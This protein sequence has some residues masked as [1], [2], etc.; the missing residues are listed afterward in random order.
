MN[1]EVTNEVMEWMN[2]EGLLELSI[3]QQGMKY[4]IENSDVLLLWHM[5]QRGVVKNNHDDLIRFL[6]G[7]GYDSVK[8]LEMVKRFKIVEKDLG[9][10][11]L[12]TQVKL[13]TANKFLNPVVR[14]EQIDDRHLGVV[15]DTNGYEVMDIST[16]NQVIIA[17]IQEGIN[18]MNQNLTP[19]QMMWIKEVGKTLK[20]SKK[21]T[22]L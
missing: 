9:N 20:Q 6:M 15:K 7:N 16:G 22:V 21:E 14:F 5:T 19:K 4:T 17:R 2:F 10:Y 3:E 12:R 13:D 11:S 8:S 18:W 1:R